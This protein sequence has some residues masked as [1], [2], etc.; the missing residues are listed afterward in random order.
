MWEVKEQAATVSP[1]WTSVALAPPESIKMSGKGEQ[2]EGGKERKGTRRHR[3]SMKILRIQL[4]LSCACNGSIRGQW[5]AWQLHT[6]HTIFSFHQAGDYSDIG[7]L[8]ANDLEWLCG[9]ELGVAPQVDLV[10]PR[11]QIPS[12]KI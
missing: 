10:V 9:D 1:F 3:S 12:A 5:R 4:Q 11:W 2:E 7:P 6:F 8:V